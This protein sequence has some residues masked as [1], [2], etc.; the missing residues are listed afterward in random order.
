[1]TF[2]EEVLLNLYVNYK[3]TQSDVERMLD[4]P[5]KALDLENS[6]TLALMKMIKVYPWLLEVADKDYDE[7]EAKRILGHNAVDIIAN[8]Q[9]NLK[10]K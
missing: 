7:I 5:M 4:L 6:E 9:A 8:E 1:M 10:K 2:I 3:Y